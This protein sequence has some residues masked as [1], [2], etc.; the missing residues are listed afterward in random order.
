MIH[1]KREPSSETLFRRNQDCFRA[2]F[3]FFLFFSFFSPNRDL[4]RVSFDCILLYIFLELRPGPDPSQ[5]RLHCTIF[6]IALHPMTMAIRRLG[7]PSFC[8]MH[9]RARAESLSRYDNS[10]RGRGERHYQRDSRN[11][12]ER[13]PPARPS[14]GPR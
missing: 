2:F 9:D 11:P 3:F 8:H 7:Q 13:R 14:T 5:S 12:R 6:T 1:R 4:T 10:D